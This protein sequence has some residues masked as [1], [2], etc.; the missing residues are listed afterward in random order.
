MQ[1]YINWKTILLKAWSIRFLALAV[2]FAAAEAAL[3]VLDQVYDIPRGLF[4][5]LTILAVVGAGVSRLVVQK[6]V[7]DPATLEVVNAL[8]DPEVLA[9]VIPL[10]DLARALEA[11]KAKESSDDAQG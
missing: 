8:T 1:L 3:P 6:S 11:A 5:T 7:D 2:A 4:A 10:D 9:K